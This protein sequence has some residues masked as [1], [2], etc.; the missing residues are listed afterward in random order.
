V[1][2]WATAELA[3]MGLAFGVAVVLTRAPVIS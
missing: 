3:V 2:G 1:A